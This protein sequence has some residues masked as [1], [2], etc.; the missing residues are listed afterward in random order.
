MIFVWLLVCNAVLTDYS[1]P[2][3]LIE[4][5][6]AVQLIGWL[7]IAG[8]GLWK[9]SRPVLP[10]L[11][12]AWVFWISL[13]GNLF[14]SVEC[15]R[16][17]GFIGLYSLNFDSDKLR[18]WAD[19]LLFPVLVL[20]WFSGSNANDLSM[21]IWVTLMV[22]NRRGRWAVIAGAV[23]MLLHSEAAIIALVVGL[24]VERWGFRAMWPA[25]PAMAIIGL[26]RGLNS[27]A[28]ERLLYWQYALSH[29]TFW[30]NGLPFQFPTTGYAHNLIMDVLYVAGLPGLGL[31]GVAGWW[32]WRNRAQFGPLGGFIA[33]F[34][35]YSLVDYPHWSVPGAVLMI[36]L[37]KYRKDQTNYG[38]TLGRRLRMY[39][40]A[41]RGYGV[42]V[43]RGAGVASVADSHRTR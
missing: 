16:L 20:P 9:G 1:L 32:L 29:F 8:Y 6:Y 27:S 37:S 4:A 19:W 40:L 23:I 10:L 28:G 30:G 43:Q 14:V 36:I 11:L 21:L 38:L 3:Q 5:V 18:G 25:F 22:S 7:G 17:L 33:G 41:R 39:F 26:M 34:A 42:S 35:V 2:F 31:L 13:P 24:A 15:T 12:W